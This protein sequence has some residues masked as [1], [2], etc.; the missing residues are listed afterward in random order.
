MAR[1]LLA[2]DHPC[3]VPG[4]V[5]AREVGAL[6]DEADV[7]VAI[8]TDFDGTMTQNWKMPAPPV[9]IALN[10]DEVEASKNYRADVTLVGDA[11]AVLEQLIPRVA[12]RQGMSEL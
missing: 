4:P 6:W 10:L 12:P 5:H 2:P 3:A 9:L 11:R 1:G 8:G 7:V